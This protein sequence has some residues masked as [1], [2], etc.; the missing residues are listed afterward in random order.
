[1][2]PKPP[3]AHSAESDK[4]SC[5]ELENGPNLSEIA[6]FCDSSLF[7]PTCDFAKRRAE[8]AG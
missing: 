8:K 4:R 6:D 2:G 3:V 7:T 1:M 5:G